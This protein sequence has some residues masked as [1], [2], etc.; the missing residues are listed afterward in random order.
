LQQPSD[1][2]SVRISGTYWENWGFLVKRF[3]LALAFSI[4]AGSAALAAD[5]PPAQANV[6][7]AAPVYNWSGFYIGGNLGVAGWSNDS[8][9]DTFGSTF[10]IKGGSSF[11]GGGQLGVNYE[12]AGGVVIGAEAMFDWLSNSKTTI[13]GTLPCHCTAT[14]NIN[15]RWLTI[16]T[17]RVGY[18]L[19]H[20]LV[21]GKGGAAWV[22]ANT[23]VL[24]V[25]NTT[26]VSLSGPSHN[27][28]WTAGAGLEWAFY[29]NWSFRAEWDFVRVGGQSFTVASTPSTAFAGDVI[30]S[31]NRALNLFTVG[32]N[33][34]FGWW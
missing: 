22:G 11:L 19:D 24:T 18:A 21:Y 7:V 29:D 30:T 32:V 16:A 9:S 23:P 17:G 3:A 15:D 6:P 12:F 26:P 1:A 13:T 5:L 28:G 10:A 14:A 20:V 4:S 31:S 34:K 8:P 2:S 33:Y 25:D 27:F